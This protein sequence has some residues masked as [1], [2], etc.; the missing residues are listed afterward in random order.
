MKFYLLLFLLS[1]FLLTE[2]K[3]EGHLTITI[4]LDVD[5]KILSGAKIIAVSEI[6]TVVSNKGD[7]GKYSLNLKFGT[8]YKLVISKKGYLDKKVN[9]DTRFPTTLRQKNYKVNINVRMFKIYKEI[10]Y[11]EFKAGLIKIKFIGNSSGGYFS[12]VIKNLQNQ[13]SLDKR[14]YSK[15]QALAK[16][17]NVEIIKKTDKLSPE[18]VSLFESKYK[19]NA[20][21][22]SRAI[23]EQAYKSANNIRARYRASSVVEYNQIIT[24]AKEVAKSE[25]ASNLSYINS[26]KSKELIA[27]NKKN[28]KFP[29]EKEIKK[30]QKNYETLLNKSD[31]S[32]K[33]SIELH[34]ADIALQRDKVSKARY[35]L[36]LMK[37]RAKTHE[38]SVLIQEREAE[39]LLAESEISETE[40]ALL[41]ANNKIQLQSYK[42]ESQQVRLYISLFFL[43]LLLVFL[44]FLY[45]NFKEKKAMNKIL[46]QKNEEITDSIEYAQK[47]QA[48]I[49][50]EIPDIQSVFS[51]AFVYFQPKD[52]VSGDFYWYKKVENK[53]FF[54]VIDCTGHGVPG[55]FVSI[56]GFD[57]L[58]RTLNEF[59][60]H[61]PATIL[62][63]LNEIVSAILTKSGKANV[64]DGMD[65][66]FC[67]FSY[68]DNILEFAGAHN[69]IYI[70]SKNSKN[71]M[72]NDKEVKPKLSSD[73]L[74]LFEIR[75]DR[76]P[77]GN[78][79]K[80]KD[81][82]NHS[83]K[84][85][86]GDL[87]YLFS[88]G[89]PD[90]FG[91]ENIEKFK[92]K[93]FKKLLL[94]IKDTEF[95]KQSATLEKT[96]SDW[97][98]NYEQIDDIC[99]MGIEI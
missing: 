14:L 99:V 24:A 21:K 13:E 81:F 28:N 37:L 8:Y 1:S 90:Q 42:I 26:K 50:P 35:I 16:E 53:L 89:F 38:D 19:A 18:L 67:S 78:Y 94:N 48:V 36:E 82:T 55:A 96:I 41:Y 34:I 32:L 80:R 77:I 17:E 95:S 11:R 58:E 29:N 68:D 92:Y 40:R 85:Q 66:A 60:L 57:G 2:S 10:N 47:I 12:Y 44:F 91:G 33:D 20:K 93:N 84:L 39:I 49:L 65:I 59:K 9:V 3:A 61:K 87:V 30:K 75:A 7:N 23:L 43:I 6:D 76:Q 74:S 46:A 64:K 83:I 45:R 72:D 70:I 62:D 15:I 88:D 69:P 52:I 79:E 63:K 51:N 71:L 25:T 56:I 22:Q 31:K 54:S 27:Q 98:G 97:K 86:K 73:E 5:G 4:G